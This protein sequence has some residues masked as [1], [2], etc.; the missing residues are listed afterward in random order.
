MQLKA[1]EWK[2]ALPADTAPATAAALAAEVDR[3]AA[4]AQYGWGHTIDFGPFVREGLFGRHF[5]VVAGLLDEW[6]WWPRDLSGLAVADVGCFT[7]GIA[8]MMAQ[9]RANVVH[10]VD[11]VP[12][13]LAQCH[14]VAEAFQ[15]SAVRT[16]QQTL[17]RLEEEIPAGSLDYIVLAGV[18][19]HL[20]DMLVGLHV[21]RR[22]LKPEGWLLIETAAVDEFRYS[23]AN[24][25]RFIGG[26]WWEPTALCIQDMLSLMNY[27]DAEIRFY[28]EERCL[29]RARNAGGEP[30]FRR[31]LNWKFD[32][33]RDARPR[34]M[35][36]AGFARAPRT[37][38]K[39]V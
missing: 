29:V 2:L 7:G 10:A 15:L 22:L 8:A 13:H 39:S 36:P 35:D 14:V 16:H 5:L 24:F 26:G 31:G 38:K 23:Y 18:L 17:Y 12:E 34:L 25:S 37:G 21:L 33:M 6:D 30:P 9:R 11:E 27:A 3:V 28:D 20:S 19:Y 1:A 32:S 4:Q